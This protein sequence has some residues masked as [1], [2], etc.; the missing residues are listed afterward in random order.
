MP[1]PPSALQ[2]S[3]PPVFAFVA[4]D[5][6]RNQWTFEEQSLYS[7]YS[8]TSRFV[9]MLERAPEALHSLSL[10]HLFVSVQPKINKYSSANTTILFRC[11][12]T[13]VCASRRRSLYDMELLL[14]TISESES[15]ESFSE[16]W[17]DEDR[18]EI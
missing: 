7:I 4:L 16:L 18:D 8:P 13:C 5:M 15:D 9:D 17:A 1:L 3:P 2:L 12:I 6:K 14:R 10:S 11:F